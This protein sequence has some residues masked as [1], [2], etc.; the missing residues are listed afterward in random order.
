M[1]S[2]KVAQKVEEFLGEVP[3]V[4][5]VD[6]ISPWDGSKVL[7]FLVV[8]SNPISY[9]ISRKIA[10]AMSSAKWNVFEKTGEFPAVE[11]EIVV[12]KPCVKDITGYSSFSP[13]N[14]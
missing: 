6:I 2:L 11:W 14:R 10:E 7:R 1:N 5:E 13:G 3:E 8:V 9:E 12:R 4:V